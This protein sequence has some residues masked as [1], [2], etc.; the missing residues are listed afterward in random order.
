MKKL[1]SPRFGLNTVRSLTLDE[2]V[3]LWLNVNIGDGT[4]L[5]EETKEL[6]A[7]IK[8]QL[9]TIKKNLNLSQYVY[10]GE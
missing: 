8:S 4:H 10:K 6:D 1:R 2:W 7:S 9:N 3:N 5:P